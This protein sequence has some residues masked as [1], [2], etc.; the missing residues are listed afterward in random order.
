MR[1][2]T[3]LLALFTLTACDMSGHPDDA[4]CLDVDPAVIVV[5]PDGRGTARLTACDSADPVTLDA[6]TTDDAVRIDPDLAPPMPA[7]LGEWVLTV[8]AARSG[9]I[10]L[11]LRDADAPLVV[12]VVVR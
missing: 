12:P 11:H 4:P 2:I 7:R 6:I 5:G 10:S 1:T 8:D 9:L 3:A